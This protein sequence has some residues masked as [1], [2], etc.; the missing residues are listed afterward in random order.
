MD[1][2]IMKTP[3]TIKELT[4]ALKDV[5]NNTYLISGG[6]DLIIKFRKDRIHSA[7]VIDLKGIKELSY[8]KEE[9]GCI[10]IG[11]GT[12][13]TEIGDHP[14]LQN[15]AACLVEG[16]CQIGSTQ[17]RNVA[18]IGGNVANAFAGADAIPGLIAMDAKVKVLNAQGETY[19]KEVEQ[20]LLGAGKNSLKPDEAIIE[21]IIPALGK[22]YQSAFA[23]VGSRSRVTI[24][25][26]NI[27][28]VVKVNEDNQM[29][30]DVRIVLGAL[31]PKA[32]RSSM[33]E[34]ILI[35]KKISE[36]VAAAFTDA[37]TK[38][39][40]LAIPGRK[41]RVYKREAVKGLGDEIYHKLFK[42]TGG[43][44]EC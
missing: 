21:I 5:D 9:D 24:A 42:K 2:M 6:T 30:E 37:L 28:A 23:K 17:I 10:K 41:S 4:E 11:A 38:Q 13:F 33:V 12:T 44:A 31:G 26:M 25:K 16:V 27:A 40:D 32:F 36:G 14:L 22:D 29:I 39:V 3:N 8:I 20:I 19:V 7:T 43:E 35:G 18:T 1:E 15:H 34:N